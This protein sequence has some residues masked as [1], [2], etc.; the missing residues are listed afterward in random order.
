MQS[1]LRRAVKN[2]RCQATRA[3]LLNVVDAFRI[4]TAAGQALSTEAVESALKAPVD[5]TTLKYYSFVFAD[6]TLKNHA[7]GVDF[8][9][10][11]SKKELTIA[12]AVVDLSVLPSGELQKIYEHAYDRQADFY[13][14]KGDVAAY[15]YVESCAPRALRSYAGFTIAASRAAIVCKVKFAAA[16]SG[17]FDFTKPSEAPSFVCCHIAIS[18]PIIT[19]QNIGAFIGE[20]EPR[21]ETSFHLRLLLDFCF[22]VA[23]VRDETRRSRFVVKD[24]SEAANPTWVH[25]TKRELQVEY[26]LQPLLSFQKFMSETLCGYFSQC[27]AHAIHKKDPTVMLVAQLS[28]G[29][30]L[31]EATRNYLFDVLRLDKKNFE[32]IEEIGATPS[33]VLA[34]LRSK[35]VLFCPTTEVQRCAVSVSFTHPLQN[36]MCLHNM[37]QLKKYLVP[38]LEFDPAAQQRTSDWTEAMNAR[39]ATVC[40]K[41]LAKYGLAAAAKVELPHVGIRT[42]KGILQLTHPPLFSPNTVA[43]WSIYSS[44]RTSA[45]KCALHGTRSVWTSAAVAGPSPRPSTWE[46][47]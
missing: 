38:T 30:E 10:N 31:D 43:L 17:A 11:G 24:Y 33:V 1:D 9:D 20:R 2:V 46:R 13:A 19:E 44:L 8:T 37:L 23:R 29:A 5:E 45:P 15:S 12:I 35:R 39:W 32:W 41:E 26:Q 21:D 25:T 47:S 28:D 36:F 42:P 4:A 14:I 18:E 40:T 7:F 16:S 22:G 6:T 3:E 27:C 34:K